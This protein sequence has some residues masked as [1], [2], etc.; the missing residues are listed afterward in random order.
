MKDIEGKLQGLVER[1]TFTSQEDGYSVIK[2]RAAG[3]RDLVTAVGNFM[4]L[5]PGESLLMEGRW[6]MHARFGRQFKVDR[7]ETSAPSTVAGI[8]KYLGS[9]LIRGIGPKMAERIVKRFAE[10]TLDIIED[11]IERLLE[12]EGIGKYRVGQIQK[13]WEEQR[14]IRALMIFLRSNGASA[15]LAA[16]IF[17]KYGQQ[18]VD[19]VRENPYRLAMEIK[20]IGFLTADKLAGNLGFSADS[21]LRAEAGIVFVLHEATE[22]GHVCLPHSLLMER[23]GKTLDIGTPILE[24][25]LSSLK[26]E[27]RIKEE[28]LSAAVSERFRR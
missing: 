13:A 16:R 5:C 25:A 17:K 3:H 15:T 8:Q 18:S 20:G 19:I 10:R 11:Q 24:D 1:V 27:K 2:V 28:K 23:C 7:Y 12:I 6:C 21:P 4:S 26:A 22:E 9:G 14:E